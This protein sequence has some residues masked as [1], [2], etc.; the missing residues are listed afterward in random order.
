M[1]NARPK[2]QCAA[3]L[4]GRE[5]LNELFEFGY[6]LAMQDYPLQTESPQLTTE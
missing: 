2:P 4:C 6:D 3:L 1:Y 5:H